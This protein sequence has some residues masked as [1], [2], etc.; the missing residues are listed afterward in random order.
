[1]SQIWNKARQ[2]PGCLRLI[3]LETDMTEGYQIACHSFPSIIY[4]KFYSLTLKY[5]NVIKFRQ[6][7]KRQIYII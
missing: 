2:S 3:Q 4:K 7:Y 5:F 1:M 6:I